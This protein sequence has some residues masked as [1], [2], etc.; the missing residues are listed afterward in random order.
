M[1]E[2]VDGPRPLLH[3]FIIYAP[4]AP[5]DIHKCIVKEGVEKIDSLRRVTIG[6]LQMI[7]QESNVEPDKVV[8]QELILAQSVKV[9]NIHLGLLLPNQRIDKGSTT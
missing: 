5:G 7:L 1:T 4:L 8:I 3:A 6:A 9:V 2:Y